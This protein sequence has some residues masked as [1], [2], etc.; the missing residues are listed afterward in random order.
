LVKRWKG[1]VYVY[2]RGTH[3]GTVFE[4]DLPGEPVGVETAD[5]HD[6]AA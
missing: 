5:E 1:K 6:H 4:V 3:P 2:G